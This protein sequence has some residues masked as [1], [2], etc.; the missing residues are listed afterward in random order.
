VPY[1][2]DC[3]TYA[4]RCAIFG[5]RGRPARSLRPVAIAGAASIAIAVP[6]AA[7]IVRAGDAA[8]RNALI[9]AS[10]TILLVPVVLQ[11]P[12]LIGLGLVAS[13]IFTVCDSIRAWW[14]EADRSE[15][16]EEAADPPEPWIKTRMVLSL[17]LLGVSPAA[18]SVLVGGQMMFWA[19]TSVSAGAAD[20]SGRAD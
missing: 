16:E 6:Q 9:M 11:S 4:G 7:P 18:W 8:F 5:C 3:W 2:A 17:I 13:L 10:P 19:V 15:E 20:A 14:R 1:H 12:A